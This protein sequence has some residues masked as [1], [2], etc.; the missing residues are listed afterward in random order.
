MSDLL[1]LTVSQLRQAAELKEKIDALSNELSA[2]FR[3]KSVSTPAR[4]LALSSAPKIKSSGKLTLGNAILEALRANGGVM[5]RTALLKATGDLQGKKINEGSFNGQLQ[6]MKG[7]G[8][9]KSP[10]RGQF[11][12][13]KVGGSAS[14][15]A[16]A[17]ASETKPKGKR[18]MSPAAR[19]KIAAAARARWAKIKGMRPQK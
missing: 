9:I 7:N 13:G 11:Q 8:A 17:A 5:D 10:G 18:T 14:T 12:I 2:I 1:T 15:P 19:A 4:S 3:G 6:T 16:P